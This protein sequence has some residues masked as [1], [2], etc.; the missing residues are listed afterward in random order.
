VVQ[1]KEKP[2]KLTDMIERLWIGLGVPKGIAR[3]YINRS[4]HWGNV[5]HAYVR[6]IADP[7]GKLPP[8]HAYVTGIKNQDSRDFIEKNQI[9]MTRIPSAVKCSQATMLKVITKK[10]DGMTDSE[11][12]WLENLPMGAIIFAFPSEGKLPIPETISGD[13]DGDRYFLCWNKDILG[14]LKNMKRYVEVNDPEAKSVKPSNTLSSSNENWLSDAQ[15]RMESVENMEV[16]ALV[17]K[18]FNLSKRFAM[19]D[20]LLGIRNPDAEAFAEAF[21]QALDNG[22]HGCK[23]ILPKHLHKEVPKRF[24]KYLTVP[25]EESTDQAT[26]SDQSTDEE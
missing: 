19:A 11:F 23:I 18:L 16:L 9:F 21:C 10:P 6:G 24:Q 12:E 20:D 8:G 3:N 15:S 26:V 5:N 17:G 25:E 2:K 22:K 4:I 7:T 13:L 14:S 1:K